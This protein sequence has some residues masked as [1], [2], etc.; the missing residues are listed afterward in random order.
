MSDT[1]PPPPPPP[2]SV[3]PPPP[4]M[5]P[6][7]SGGVGGYSGWPSRVGATLTRSFVPVV[8]IWVAV[9]IGGAIGG[10]GWLVA[11]AGYVFGIA[12]QIRFLIQRGHLGYDAGDAV[13]KQ[14][15]IKESTNAPMGSGWSVFGR[16]IVHIL[17]AIPCYIGFLWPLWDSKRQTFA[18]KVL[19]T[20]VVRDESQQHSAA[21]LFKNAFMFWTPV[22]KS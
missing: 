12:A 18:D 10:I 1:P 11:I 8:V 14:R 13:T 9:G 20:V 2:S 15:L 3:P 5:S 19:T 4:P 22:T 16:S 6:P 21:D 17:D 7:P